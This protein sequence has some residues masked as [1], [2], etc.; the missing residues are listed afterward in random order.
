MAT[1]GGSMAVLTLVQACPAQCVIC[2]P[3]PENHLTEDVVDLGIGHDLLL[4]RNVVLLAFDL[5]HG[6]RAPET[7]VITSY[8]I[9]YTKLYEP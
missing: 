7:V 9:H 1:V 3:Q 8:S 6:S 2:G 4:W 5:G